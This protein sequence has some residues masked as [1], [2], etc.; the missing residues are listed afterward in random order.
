MPTQ[1]PALGTMLNTT[2][3]N[4]PMSPCLTIPPGGVSVEGHLDVPPPVGIGHPSGRHRVGGEIS[5]EEGRLW[6]GE[7]SM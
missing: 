6:I 3:P 5:A 1:W 4:D 7:S 2:L